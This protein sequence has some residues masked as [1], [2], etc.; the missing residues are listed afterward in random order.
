MATAQ[1][2]L[3]RNTYS[4][5]QGSLKQAGKNQ[6]FDMVVDTPNFSAAVT[7]APQGATAID[8]AFPYRTKQAHI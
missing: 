1:T 2:S 3:R 5:D 7:S 8:T 4:K 6:T